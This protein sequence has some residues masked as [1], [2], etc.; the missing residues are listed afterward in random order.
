MSRAMGQPI[1]S[2]MR[3]K[4][5]IKQSL[6]S[7]R[8]ILPADLTIAAKKTDLGEAKRRDRHNQYGAVAMSPRLAARRGKK[9]L[10]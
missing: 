2:H 9:S 4:E 3:R 8:R 7:V 5:N 6:A 1:L 10:S